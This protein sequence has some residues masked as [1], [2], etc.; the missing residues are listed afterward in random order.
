[1]VSA[2]VASV[3]SG[4]AMVATSVGTA[5]GSA[6]PAPQADKTIVAPKS[7]A[8]MS[9]DHLLKRIGRILEVSVFCWVFIGLICSLSVLNVG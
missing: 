6:S 7:I 8:V 2:S 1:V 3:A 5:T 9:A 4:A